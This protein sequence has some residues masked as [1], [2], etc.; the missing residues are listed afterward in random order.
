MDSVTS[1]I[2]EKLHIS[3]REAVKT[4]P[5]ISKLLNQDE[6]LENYFDFEDKETEFIKKF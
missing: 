1:K 3:G 5:F 4:L 2:G 6:N